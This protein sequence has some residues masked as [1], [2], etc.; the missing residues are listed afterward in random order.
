MAH[1]R[2]RRQRGSS[3]HRFE[4]L[5]AEGRSLGGERSADT[6][7]QAVHAAPSVWSKHRFYLFSMVF[8][9]KRECSPEFIDEIM[10]QFVYDEN[11]PAHFRSLAVF[12][13]AQRFSRLTPQL[14]LS[15]AAE[16]CRQ[17]LDIIASSSE[18]DEDRQVLYHPYIYLYLATD[19]VVLRDA[20][21]RL[22][23]ILI[24]LQEKIEHQLSLCTG[25][26]PEAG[27]PKP[28]HV[29]TLSERA[30]AGGLMCDCCGKTLVELQLDY[31]ERCE[32][33]KQVFYCSK[34]CQKKHW[35]RKGHKQA[36]RAPGQI[37]IGD[38]MLLV[39]H[40]GSEEEH[41]FVDVIS[42]LGGRRWQV[43][44]CMSNELSTV[45][46]ADLLQYFRPPSTLYRSA[47]GPVETSSPSLLLP[48]APAADAPVVVTTQLISLVPAGVPVTQQQTSGTNHDNS[49]ASAVPHD[50]S[51]QWAHDNVVLSEDWSSWWKWN[52]SPCLYFLVCIGCIWSWYLS[53]IFRY[54]S[55]S[56]WSL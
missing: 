18:E 46:G 22:K 21:S 53:M 1:R 6:Y 17:G 42:S 29:E 7:L 55:C 38:L 14:N 24:Y 54:S 44:F 26:S 4:T 19:D 40:N 12:W 36:C 49:N 33:C 23:H 15:T 13:A 20:D 28:G 48:D 27:L 56:C 52:A 25:S 50:P 5:F 11:E 51:V 9:L 35:K 8:I 30:S 10:E 16:L 45:D 41:E 43:K 3:Q 2:Q 39:L 31:L 47:S 34:K 32:R 37:E